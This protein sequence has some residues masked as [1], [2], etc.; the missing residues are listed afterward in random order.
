ME[1]CLLNF[2]KFRHS[3]FHGGGGGINKVTYSA[4]YI[5]CQQGGENIKIVES[6]TTVKVKKKLES[7]NIAVIFLKFEQWAFTIH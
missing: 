6:G 1:I 4:L 2:I 7:E 3:L 5:P